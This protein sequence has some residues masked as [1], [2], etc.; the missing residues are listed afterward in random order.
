MHI[1]FFI[2]FFINFTFIKFVVLPEVGTLLPHKSQIPSF[3]PVFW[4][5]CQIALLFVELGLI[6]EGKLWTTALLTVEELP[7]MLLAV[8]LVG[9]EEG[10]MVLDETILTIEAMSNEKLTLEEV[11]KKK[12]T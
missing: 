12:G 10:M 9:G 4:K 7:L 6:V 2:I 3:S 8:D 5:Y 1:I 11:R